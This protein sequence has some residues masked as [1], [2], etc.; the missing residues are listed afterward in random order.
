MISLEFRPN[1]SSVRRRLQSCRPT[2]PI[3]FLSMTPP[4]HDPPKP[5]GYCPSPT[6][7]HYKDLMPPL[8]SPTLENMEIWDRTVGTRMNRVLRPPLSIEESLENAMKFPSSP[9]KKKGRA[10]T[11]TDSS[12]L[13]PTRSPKESSPPA[14]MPTLSPKESGSPPSKKSKVLNLDAAPKVTP[15]KKPK[16]VLTKAQSKSSTLMLSLKRLMRYV[17]EFAKMEGRSQRPHR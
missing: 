8:S 12:A 10:R 17:R 3:P 14:L 16:E 9:S 7:K 2:N 1:S 5:K 4:H 13:K 15:V 11:K 6:F